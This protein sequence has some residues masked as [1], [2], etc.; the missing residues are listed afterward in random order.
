MIVLL[1]ASGY[2]GSAFS[3]Q[4]KADGVPFISPVRKD[5]DYSNFPS[6]VQFLHQ[7]KP[8]FLINA[9]GYTGKPN[10]DACEQHK[11]DTI[12]GNVLLPLT[13]AQACH[14]TNTP[15]AHVSSGCIFSGAKILKNGMEMIVKDLTSPEAD[16]ILR[17]EKTSIRGFNEWDT[18][19]FS[20]RNLPCSFY[21]G[22]KALAEEAISPYPNCYIWRLRIP[23]DEEDNSRNYL[24]K[25]QRYSKVYQNVNSLS[26]RKD[27]TAACLG[28]WKK[29]APFGIYNVTNPGFVTTR[30]VVELI[31]KHLDI[32]RQFAFWKDD[33]EFYRLAASTPRSNCVLDSSKLLD[34]GVKLRTVHEAL[35]DS[36]KNWKKEAK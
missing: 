6:L 24:S 13:I 21:S 16:H 2:I 1:G 4:L 14:S 17:E 20:F 10:V 23:F 3:Q 35:I 26:H 18:P 7:T 11:A 32:N 19:N 31:Q 22:T 36:L 5:L 34:T 29:R 28:L 30:E 8:E 27:F 25:I 12:N 9:A 15:W 33:A